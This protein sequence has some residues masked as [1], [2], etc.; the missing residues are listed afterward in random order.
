M[1]KDGRQ[2]RWLSYIL[3]TLWFFSMGL[4]GFFFPYLTDN[5]DYFKIKAL[6]IEGL[7][8][9]P[10]E[11]VIDEIRR[12]K[13]NWLFINNKSL[14]KNLNSKTGNAVSMVKIDRVFGSEGVKLKI[15]IEERKPIFT[16]IKDDAIYFFDKNGVL[17]QSEYMKV[18]KPLVYTHDIELVMKNFNKLTMLIN[19][20]GK[21]LREIYI[22]NLNTIAYTQEG[23]KIIMPPIFLFSEQVVENV[24]NTLK[25]Y[26]IGMSGKELDLSVEGLVIIREMKR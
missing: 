14:L 17:F 15:F 5:I 26:N 12:F 13:N 3:S 23:T 7:E 11:V 16:V 6:Q 20:L 2:G 19:V 25:V 18:V 22:T 21:E 1:R 8:T 9:I 24:I 10:S 4:F